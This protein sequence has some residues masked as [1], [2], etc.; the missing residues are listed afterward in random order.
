MSNETSDLSA[1]LAE[2]VA[3]AAEC[4]SI[5]AEIAALGEKGVGCSDVQE[6]GWGA[7]TT[8]RLPGGGEVGLYQPRHPT[9]LKSN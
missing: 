9:A 1:V 6:A 7:V 4:E 3:L 2:N 5:K 8:I